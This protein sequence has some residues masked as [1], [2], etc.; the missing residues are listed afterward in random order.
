MPHKQ[1]ITGQDVKTEK[2]E[3]AQDMRR[4]MTP[5]EARLWQH[6]RAGRLES[7]HFRRQQVIGPF[8]ADFYCHQVDLVVEV[9]G[10]VHLSQVEYDQARDLYLQERGLSVLRFTNQDVESNLEAVLAEILEAC[11]AAAAAQ[12]LG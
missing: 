11:R 2:L 4:K 9:D 6:I 12:L 8:I 10:S 5:A 1:I 3:R 7:F